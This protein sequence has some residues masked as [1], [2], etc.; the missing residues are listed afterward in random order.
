MS[1]DPW[2]RRHFGF[3]FHPIRW[4]GCALTAALIA[5]ELPIM[6]L[7]RNAQVDSLLWWLSS[8]SAFAVFLLFFWIVL[9]KTEDT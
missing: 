4:Q 6:W 9:S 2:F 5:V 1:E 3:G 7:S 8:G